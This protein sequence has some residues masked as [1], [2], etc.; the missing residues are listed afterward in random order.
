MA[1]KT[2]QIIGRA[3]RNWMVRGYMGRSRRGFCYTKYLNESG[4]LEDFGTVGIGSPANPFLT[5]PARK[6][7]NGTISSPTLAFSR[8]PM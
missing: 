7:A 2:G 4:Y 5:S 3:P 6:S 8:A 1:R